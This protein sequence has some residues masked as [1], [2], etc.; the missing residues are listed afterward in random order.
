MARA[1]HRK[2]GESTEITLPIVDPNTIGRLEI[3]ADIEVRE[4][5]AVHVTEHR[6]EPEIR[7]RSPERLAIGIQESAICPR[8]ACEFPVSIIEVESVWFT[9]FDEL[10]VNEL[11]A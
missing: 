9:I 11:E 10:A 1:T 5:V 7:W 2:V 6:R 3:V 4:S 8:G